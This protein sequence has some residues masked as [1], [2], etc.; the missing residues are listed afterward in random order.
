MVSSRR[1]PGFFFYLSLCRVFMFIIYF[2]AVVGFFFYLPYT[3]LL[4]V[5]EHMLTELALLGSGHHDTT[6]RLMWSNGRLLDYGN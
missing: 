4:L 2:S 3:V 1:L 5:I 6:A